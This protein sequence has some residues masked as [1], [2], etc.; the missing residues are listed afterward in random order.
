MAWHSS[1]AT[2]DDIGYRISDVG[3][4]SDA[5]GEEPITT[6]RA[7]LRSLP[8]AMPRYETLSNPHSFASEKYTLV[9]KFSRCPR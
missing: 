4:G 6:R 2:V 9:A 3:V 8:S 5:A 7:D 1:L